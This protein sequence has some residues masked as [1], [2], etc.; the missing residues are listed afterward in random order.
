MLTL[1][2]CPVTGWPVDDTLSGTGIKYSKE[3][4]KG[5]KFS[6]VEAAMTW[7]SRNLTHIW[8]NVWSWTSHCTFWASKQIVCKTRKEGYSVT[9][10]KH[11]FSSAC[12]SPDEILNRRPMCNIPGEQWLRWRWGNPKLMSWPSSP[13]VRPPRHLWRTLGALR[14]TVWKAT[15]MLL[16]S[17]IILTFTVA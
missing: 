8:E 14:N 17:I 9:F 4:K 13:F 2:F 3:S 11:G 6:V 12:L 15:A 7:V 16:R 1:N 5:A 10:F